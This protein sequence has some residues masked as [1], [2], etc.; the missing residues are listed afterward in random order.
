MVG[1]ENSKAVR[2]E[3]RLSELTE[4]DTRIT[5]Y[6]DRRAHSLNLALVSDLWSRHLH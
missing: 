6:C 5:T 4:I 3:R 1:Y 2:D